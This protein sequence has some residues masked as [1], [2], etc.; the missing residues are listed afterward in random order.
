MKQIQLLTILSLLSFFLIGCSSRPSSPPKTVS[1]VDL[2]RYLGDWYEIASY[3]QWFQEGCTA[4]QATYSLIE[5]GKVKVLNSC[6]LENPET[7]KVKAAEGVAWVVEHSSNAKLKVQFPLSSWFQTSFLAG[8]YWIID[9]D[10]EYQYA[11][12]SDPNKEY[13][14]ILYRKPKMEEAQLKTLLEKL[15]NWG[16][17]L[18]R[19]QY[20]RHTEG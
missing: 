18:D 14:W 11:I 3:P 19:I 8:D 7:G 6:R 10:S 2:E 16:Y 4:T 1:H 13:L 15:K 20:T 12:V 9:L 5:P 17:N